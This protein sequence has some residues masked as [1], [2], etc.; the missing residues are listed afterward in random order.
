MPQ[1][2][3]LSGSTF[4]CLPISGIEEQGQQHYHFPVA[5][6]GIFQIL[7]LD[8][9]VLTGSSLS[10]T[11]HISLVTMSGL[12]TSAIYFDAVYFSIPL[13]PISLSPAW[14]RLLEHCKQGVHP[15]AHGPH[16]AQD[17]C[18]CDPT[19]NRKFTLKEMFL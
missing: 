8:P 5:Q 7:G 14:F 17:G 18:E 1:L 9:Q 15:V 12:P 2:T 19:Q 3:L 11:P 6:S 13:S 10:S 16:A 4:L